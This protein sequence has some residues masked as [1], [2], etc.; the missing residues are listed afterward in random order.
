MCPKFSNEV[1]S[2]SITSEGAS[3]GHKKGQ[4]PDKE[5][6]C[7]MKG[8]REV[9]ICGSGQFSFFQFSGVLFPFAD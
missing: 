9:T 6:P 7:P 1:R 4:D 3:N 8:K 5:R 2:E